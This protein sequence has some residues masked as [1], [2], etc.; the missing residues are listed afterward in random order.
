MRNILFSLGVILFFS[1]RLTLLAQNDEL[2]KLSDPVPPAILLFEPTLFASPSPASLPGWIAGVGQEGGLA[3]E[4]AWHVAESTPPGMGRIWIDLNRDVLN[5]NLA[6]TLVSERQTPSDLIIQLCDASGQ[7]VVLDLFGNIMAAAVESRADTF[8]IPLRKFP[9]VSRIVLRRISGEPTLYGT[10]LVPVV[11]EKEAG[12]NL[13]EQ[14]QLARFLG[15]RLSPENELVR[16]VRAITGAG[17]NVVKSAQ[18]FIPAAVT[19]MRPVP[20][21]IKPTAAPSMDRNLKWQQEPPF[22]VACGMLTATVIGGRIYATGG[23]NGRWNSHVYCYDPAQPAPKWVAE[24]NMPEG[25]ACHAAVTVGGKLYSIGGQGNNGAQSS[26]YVYDPGAPETGWIKIKDL[27]NPLV[28]VS[29]V[30]VHDKIYVIGGYSRS[31]AERAVYEYDPR[32]PDQGWRFINNLPQARYAA[33]AIVLDGRIYVAGGTAERSCQPTVYTFDPLRPDTGW[34]NV[35]DMP[36]SRGILALAPVNGKLMAMGGKSDSS[37]K[38]TSTVY[39]F[40]PSRPDQG[41][42]EETSLP[43]VMGE[44]PAVVVNKTVYIISGARAPCSYKSSVFSGSLATN[45]VR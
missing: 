27:P 42:H 25:R 15:D 6:I 35:N 3:D 37:A 14:L 8:V 5:E 2:A 38:S 23:Y 39:I 40:D 4:S 31:G 18:A 16:R 9:T 44:A 22:P 28:W 11:L 10:A 34:Q 19:P 13:V 33:A 12:S 26:V 43:E 17:S 7:V 1:P 41:W 36:A 30:A 32:Q 20:P 29:A 21:T 24:P 45:W